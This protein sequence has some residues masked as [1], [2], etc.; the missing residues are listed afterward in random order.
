MICFLAQLIK[1]DNTKKL[2]NDQSNISPEISPLDELEDALNQPISELLKIITAALFSLNYGEKC[3]DLMLDFV[4]YLVG[5]LQPSHNKF[6]ASKLQLM[7]SC[8][9]ECVWRACEARLQKIDL[10]EDKAKFKSVFDRKFEEL[11]KVCHFR[12]FSVGSLVTFKKEMLDLLDVYVD[13][14]EYL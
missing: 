3:R 12:S 14:L 10:Q 4:F 11:V 9:T 2:L 7:Y 1:I 6:L 5:G 13:K 8:M